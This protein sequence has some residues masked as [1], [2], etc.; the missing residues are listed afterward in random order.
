[1]PILFPVQVSLRDQRLET[2]TRD[3]IAYLITRISIGASADELHFLRGKINIYVAVAVVHL[4]RYKS[5][6]RRLSF[7]TGKISYHVHVPPVFLF[8]CSAVCHLEFSR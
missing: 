4:K 1:M 3:Y 2:E 6:N 8:S 5:I 7:A